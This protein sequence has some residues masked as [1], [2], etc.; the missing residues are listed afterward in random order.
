[1]RNEQSGRR[2]HGNDAERMRTILIADCDIFTRDEGVR[3]KTIACL[4]IV[5]SVSIAVKDPAGVLLASGLMNRLS[6]LFILGL[7]KTVYPAG[8]VMRSREHCNG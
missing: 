8:F 7:P 4:I 1:M 2:L 5:G 6:H 3:A